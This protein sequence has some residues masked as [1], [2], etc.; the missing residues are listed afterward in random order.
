MDTVEIKRVSFIR[1]FAGLC[2]IR[3]QVFIREQGVPSDLEW[4]G[5]DQ[6][7]VHLLA[8]TPSQQAVGTIRILND[9]HIGRMAVLDEWRN[10]GI[11]SQLL[12]QIL[13]VARQR[14][15][16][17]V[18]LAAQTTAVDFYTRYGFIPEGDVFLDAGIEHQNMRLTL[19]E[20]TRSTQNGN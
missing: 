19:H 3:E 14:G 1:D 8:V 18:F 5:L 9:G 13:D 10:R 20:E 2:Y 15:L 17:Q 6:D 12:K 11:G 16:E 4:D 7:A